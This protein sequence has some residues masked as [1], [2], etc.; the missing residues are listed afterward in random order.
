MTIEASVRA[1]GEAIDGQFRPGVV[2]D[3][4][5]L[6]LRTLVLVEYDAGPIRIGGELQDSRAYFERRGGSVSTTEV[7]ALEP[8]QAYVAADLDDDV[9]VQ[10]GRFALSLGSRRLVS[11]NNFRNTINGFTGINAR[12]TSAALG[13]T[14]LF[15]MSPNLRL[16]NNREGL[17]DD[18]VEL[19]RDDAG[20]RLFGAFTSRK[21]TFG[22]TVDIGL[23]RLAE[24][25]F[26]RTATR[27]RR[28]WTL[29]G[30]YRVAPRRGAWDG[31]IEAAGQWG[32]IATSAL[33]GAARVPVRAGFRQGAGRVVP[34][35]GRRRSAE[36][37]DRHAGVRRAGTIQRE[38]GRRP[39]GHDR[40]QPRLRDP[41]QAALGGQGDRRGRGQPHAP[42]LT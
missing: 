14:H 7:N 24:H 32:S 42:L 21:A 6:L 39:G 36:R 40:E 11:R 22:G 20:A 31:E 41:L 12:V 30:R 15:W 25:D 4:A 16:P 5:A 27:D 38:L 2:A 29:D 13:E 35:E 8:L 10:A 23:L 33:A 17:L 37:P 28:L 26:N 3:D 34:G 19:D 18:V 9:S 1:R